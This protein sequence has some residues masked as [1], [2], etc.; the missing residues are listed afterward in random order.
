MIKECLQ[1]NIMPFIIDHEH[2]LFYYRGLKEYRS[3][4][5][6][7]MD[8]CQSAQDRYEAQVDY[9]FPELRNSGHE[10]E[11]HPGPNQSL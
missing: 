10:P 6:Y 3:E 11:T 1:H 7:L 4:K 8:T 5:G 9:F 2:K